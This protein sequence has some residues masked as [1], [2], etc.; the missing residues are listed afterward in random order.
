MAELSL[1]T[2]RLCC[3]AWVLSRVSYP[4]S[5]TCLAVTKSAD[6]SRCPDLFRR[7]AV[8]LRGQGRVPSW[9]CILT[10]RQKEL[11]APEDSRGPSLWGRKKPCYLDFWNLPRS[12][13]P[14]WEWPVAQG[15][16]HWIR[17]TLSLFFMEFTCSGRWEHRKMYEITPRGNS[18]EKTCPQRPDRCWEGIGIRSTV[19]LGASEGASL[20]RRHR[21]GD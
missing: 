1:C 11:G 16:Q 17:S 10:G 7:A 4:I 13:G 15:R 18:R 5:G 12:G 20:R 21:I 8:N 3:G 9:L 19:Y 14:I 6:W 2:Q